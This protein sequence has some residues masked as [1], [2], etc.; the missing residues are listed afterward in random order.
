[1][2]NSFVRPLQSR[3]RRLPNRTGQNE[4]AWQATPCVLFKHTDQTMEE[5]LLLLL[6]VVLWG[7][8]GRWRRSRRGRALRARMAG[9]SMR[10]IS[11]AH[12][13][14]GARAGDARRI[15]FRLL[16]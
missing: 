4:E 11:R 13:P 7:R 10:R 9:G 5:A 6:L 12:E 2:T 8:A 1:M 15:F 14:I 16:W 3:R